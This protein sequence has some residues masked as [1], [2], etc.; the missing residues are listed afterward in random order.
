MRI[1]QTLSSFETALKTALTWQQSL[2]SI[3]LLVA[4]LTGAA[5]Y[6]AGPPEI[7]VRSLDDPIQVVRT[8]ALLTMSPAVDENSQEYKLALLHP[9]QGLYSLT[10]CT[11]RH[12]AYYRVPRNSWDVLVSRVEEAA[13]QVGPALEQISQTARNTIT[14]KL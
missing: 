1:H 5:C 4:V 10:I 9:P 11:P 6:F 2:L 14:K 12:L 7:A 8:P 13:R 3:G